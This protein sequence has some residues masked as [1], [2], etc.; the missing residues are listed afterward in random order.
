MRQR[1]AAMVKAGLERSGHYKRALA[2]VRFPGVAVLAYHGIR[3]D[4]W[5][6]GSMAFE[7]L[8]L[9]SSTFA[10]HC[11]IVREACHPISLDAWRASL[12]GGP[13]LPDRPVLITFDDGYRSVATLAAPV[14]AALG[15]PAVV[16]ACSGPIEHRSLLW[17]DALAAREGEAAVEPSK[18]LDHARWLAAC[19]TPV[20]VADDDPRALMTPDDT[21]GLAAHGIELGGHTVWHSVLARSDAAEQHAAIARNREA[22][23]R[24]SGQP[25][26]AFAYPNGRPRIDYDDRTVA[27]VRESGF[28]F[29]FT[30]RG[31]FATPGEPRFEHSRF[32]MLS[33]VTGAELAHRLAYTWPR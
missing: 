19:G 33:A 3:G 24:W 29:G 8:H 23:E 7:N 1:V 10:D 20:T 14:L 18:G 32:M 12:A 17:F 30:T 16:F 11:A 9:R 4:D 27:I 21:R 31:A 5:R 22:L 28:D 13:P 25:V 6:A 2:R 26:R 15:L